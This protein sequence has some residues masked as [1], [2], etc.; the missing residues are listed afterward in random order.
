MIKRKGFSVAEALVSLLVF[1][2]ILGMCAPLFSKRTQVPSLDM[3]GSGVPSG[4]ILMWSGAIANIPD[5]FALC[6]GTNGT[7]DLSGKFVVG[8]NSA[9]SDYNT[10]GNTGGEPE[11]TL[12][13]AQLPSHTHFIAA[14]VKAATGTSSTLT[15]T[16]YFAAARG[17]GGTTE[18]Y[19][20][21]GV[22]SSATVGLTSSVGE[23]SEFENRPPFFVVAYI[24]KL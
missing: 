20:S 8:Y 4:V 2:V 6:D 12:T 5:G 19:S 1:S 24:M 21:A 14:N 13:E 17:D 22:A 16:T 15:N 7:P 9:D 23:G 3:A 11:N 10:I 18:N